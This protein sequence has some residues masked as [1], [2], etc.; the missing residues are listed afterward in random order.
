[1][2]NVWVN[3]NDFKKLAAIDRITCN[4]ILKW[5]RR[6]I[7]KPLVRREEDGTHSVKVPKEILKREK[8]KD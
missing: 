3:Q 5:K 4:N 6:K 1:M 8:E 2:D 7:I